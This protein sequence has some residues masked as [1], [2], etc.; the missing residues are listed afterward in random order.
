ME[1]S[2]RMESLRRTGTGVYS[3][4]ED[5]VKRVQQ[6]LAQ[7]GAVKTKDTTEEF[8]KSL[9]QVGAMEV[10]M[11]LESL[12]RTWNRGVT[13]TIVTAVGTVKLKAVTEKFT[14]NWHM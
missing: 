6:E 1:L 5:E 8:K 4:T 7:V 14:M 12:M 10:S 3:E 2:I 9:S 11:R 13:V